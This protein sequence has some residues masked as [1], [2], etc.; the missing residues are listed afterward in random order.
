MAPARE[1]ARLIFGQ[2]VYLAA[3]VDASALDS[4]VKL[5]LGFRDRNFAF[6]PTIGRD[7][8][9]NLVWLEAGSPGASDAMS[10]LGQFEANVNAGG[11]DSGTQAGLVRASAD[12]G[13]PAVGISSGLEKFFSTGAAA[14]ILSDGFNVKLCEEYVASSP[15]APTP[16]A[17]QQAEAAAPQPAKLVAP[18]TVR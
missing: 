5:T 4:G 16:A 7:A 13:A 11:A 12:G 1:G 18:E 8:A 17:A 14:R 6:V 2:Q 10:V 9:G 3:A 15:P